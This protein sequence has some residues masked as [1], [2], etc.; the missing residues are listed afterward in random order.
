VPV[1]F[2]ETSMTTPTTPDQARKLADQLDDRSLSGV[3]HPSIL[4][5]SLAQQVEALTIRDQL[6]DHRVATAVKLAHEDVDGMTRQVEALTAERDQWQASAKAAREE[7][8]RLAV[9]RDQLQLAEEGA[10]TAFGH[11]VQQKTE[12]EAEVKKIGELLAGSYKTAALV[13]A[14]ERE[15]IATW[16]A[17]EGWLLDEKDVLDAIRARSQQTGASS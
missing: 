14:A 13:A 17:K 16:Y 9:E 4:L 11:V 7:A 6:A 5:R 15:D 1:F 8:D 2:G 12:L 10:K 3:S